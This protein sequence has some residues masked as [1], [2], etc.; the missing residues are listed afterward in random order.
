VPHAP[1]YFFPFHL[2]PYAGGLLS[3]EWTV[4]YLP[5]LGL[6]GPGREEG[7][8]RAR[9]IDSF[10]MDFTGG[11][12]HDLPEIAG[13]EDEARAVAACF[14]AAAKTG[15]AATETAMVDALANAKRIHLSTHGLH[16]VNAPSFQRVYLTPDRE[17]DGI[18]Y[19]WE[20]LRYDLRGLDVLTLSACETALGRIDKGDNLRGLAAN[21]LVAGASTVVGTLWPVRSEVTKTFFESFYGE[22][23]GGSEKR[24]AFHIAQLTARDKHPEFRDWGAFNYTGFW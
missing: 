18:L 7:P 24:E 6:L 11:V 22:I 2:L 23:A 12:P 15:S 4:T 19:A 16:A 10:G 3:D 14:G 5:A 21:A 20:L 8:A 17:N 13:S 1:L 9:E